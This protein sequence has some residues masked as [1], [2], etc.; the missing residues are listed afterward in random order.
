MMRRS[1]IARPIVA[2]TVLALSAVALMTG[3]ATG[4]DYE[5]PETSL[6]RS[7]AAAAPFVSAESEEFT[8]APLPDKWWQL[9]DDPGLDSL[10]EE[11]L[12]A[13]TDLQVAD[14]NLR[15]AS[16]VLRGAV[17]SRRVQTTVSGGADLSRPS[18]TGYDLPGVLGYDAGISAGLPLDLSGRI[19]RAIEAAEADEAVVRAAR[20]DVRVAVAAGVTRAYASVCAAN[21]ELA[22]NRRVAALQRQTL[23]VTQR[24]QRGGRGTAFDVTR[25]RAAVDESEAALPAFEAARQA[26]L[27]LLAAL[28]GRLPADFPQDVAGCATLPSLEEP[29]PVGDGAALLRRRPDVR[30]AERQL[31][32]DTARVG[33]AVANLYPQV[34]IGGSVGVA[35][36]LGD[37][38]APSSFGFSLGPLI[39]WSFPDRSAVRA[40]IAQAGAQADADLAALDGTV[41]EALR[42]TET[43]L[44]AYRRGQQQVLALRRARDSAAQAA[45]Q[46]G[47]LFRFGRADFLQV[48]DT[49]RSLASAETALAA[50][51]TAR[52][53][54]QVSIF[55]ALG[56]GWQG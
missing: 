41:I 1:D 25:A 45:D 24:L 20:D 23:D 56:G 50:A 51:Q 22:A 35:G 46:A 29:M 37:L 31:A 33:V 11:A 21:F 9:Y 27:F 43:A 54:E 38:G 26:N 3:C 48:L 4:P 55:L 14:A 10:V 12:A 13:N 8:V 18:E 19:G 44:D 40:Q 32:A 39:N 28:M 16:A 2:R 47:R 5:L 6:A 42:E 53:N 49:Q 7:E 52:V 17:S 30:A 36:A 15:R 34:S